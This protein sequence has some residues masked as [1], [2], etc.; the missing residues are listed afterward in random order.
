MTILNCKI[1]YGVPQKIY[2]HLKKNVWLFKNMIH[3][4]ANATMLTAAKNCI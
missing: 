2:G 1:V 3:Q 4:Q